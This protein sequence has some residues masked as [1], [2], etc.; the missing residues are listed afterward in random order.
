MSNDKLSREEY[1]KAMK[2][3]VNSS[4]YYRHIG[5]EVIEAG[6]GRSRLRL[7]EGKPLANLF[8]ILHG[9]VT[10]SLIDSACGVALGS[11]LE[12]GEI[13]VTADLHVNYIAPAPCGV[14]I[15]EG[16]VIHKGKNTG[17]AEATVRGPDGALISKGISTHIID[18]RK[19][20][21]R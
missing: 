21:G 1:L 4:P 5:M 10:A 19:A 20:G 7:H 11:I 16:E 3:A 2:E 12:P 13:A 9:G 18:H 6:E 15:S 17:V 14:L 8:G